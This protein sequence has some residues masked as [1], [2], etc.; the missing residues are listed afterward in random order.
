MEHRYLA[1][2]F[3]GL[4]ENN[5]YYRMA[6]GWT[7]GTADLFLDCCTKLDVKMH[8]FPATS[9]FPLSSSTMQK[10]PLHNLLHPSSPISFPPPNTADDPQ[11]LS[12]L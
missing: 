10:L 1:N 2:Q 4:E 12:S 7:D 6:P 9:H 3:A 8:P 5:G 11:G